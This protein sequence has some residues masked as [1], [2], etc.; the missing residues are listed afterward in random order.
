MMQAILALLLLMILFGLAGS[1]D[2]EDRTAGLGCD[3]MPEV[4]RE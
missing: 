1:M 3:M 4:A 2:Y